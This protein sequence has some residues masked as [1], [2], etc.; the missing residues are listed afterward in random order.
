[1]LIDTRLLTFIITMTLKGVDSDFSR[2]NGWQCHDQTKLLF[3]RSI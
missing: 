3:W 1:M 2:K